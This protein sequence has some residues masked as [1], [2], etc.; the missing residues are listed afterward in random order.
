MTQPGMRITVD[1]AMRARD[2]SRPS[3]EGVDPEPPPAPAPPAEPAKPRKGERRRLG[4]RAA[5]SQ[6]TDP[7][8]AGPDHGE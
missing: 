2:V 4:K 5:N 8:A 3:P 6:R 7:R 1:A